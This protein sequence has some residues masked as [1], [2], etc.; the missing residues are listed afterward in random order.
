M[1]FDDGFVGG[2][3]F[4][5]VGASHNF[6]LG[7]SASET[8]FS[9]L[10]GNNFGH[11]VVGS[12]FGIEEFNRIDVFLGYLEVRKLRIVVLFSAA[13]HVLTNATIFALP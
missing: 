9:M 5:R 1:I 4:G 3:D 2:K 6:M 12:Y 7:L 13:L 11:V 10:K 8:L